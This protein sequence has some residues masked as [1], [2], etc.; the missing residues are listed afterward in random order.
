MTDAIMPYDRKNAIG[1]KKVLR[2]NGFGA[3]K[4]VLL[5][6][7]FKNVLLQIFSMSIGVV[8]KVII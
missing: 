3:V 2:E 5:I 6:A 1:G 4:T 8:F 7:I